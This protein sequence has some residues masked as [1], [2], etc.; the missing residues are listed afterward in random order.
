MPVKVNI[1]MTVAYFEY[2]VSIMCSVLLFFGFF[3]SIGNSVSISCW[4]ITVISGVSGP[5]S[6][7]M[8]MLEQHLE[9]I[10]VGFALFYDVVK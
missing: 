8:L 10:L 6:A 4:I 1:K 3:L 7:I 2:S 5:G 9:L